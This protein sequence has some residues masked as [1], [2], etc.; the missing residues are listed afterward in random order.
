MTQFDLKDIRRIYSQFPTGVTVITTV[1]E[2]GEPVGMTASSFNTVSIEPPLILWSID[3]G[4]YSLSTFENCKYFAVNIL[5]DEQVDISNRFAS[6]GEDKFSGVEYEKGQ[7]DCPL[8]PGALAQLECSNWA[9]YEGGDHLILVGEVKNFRHNENQS[10]LVFSQ[11]SYAQVVPHVSSAQ[12]TETLS[13]HQQAFLDNHLLYLLRNAYNTHS[14]ELYQIFADEMGISPDQW[15]VL[16]SLSSGESMPLSELCELVMQ[17]YDRLLDTI[18]S[19]DKE[20]VAVIQKQG[21]L[22]EKGLALSHQ[23]LAI[24]HQYDKQLADKIG[25]KNMQQFKEELKALR[26]A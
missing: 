11:G 6:R 18:D 5:S 22:T 10:P 15:R 20:H 1:T 9:V 23:L 3:K 12:A 14:H 24:A 2:T 17:P 25:Q 4:A 13:Q 19:M 21:Q 26:N 8:L 16:A 7:G